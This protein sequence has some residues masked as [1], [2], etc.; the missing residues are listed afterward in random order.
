MNRK[1]MQKKTFLK[2]YRAVL[3]LSVLAIISA[4]Q[5]E[6]GF[7]LFHKLESYNI[8]DR[9]Q[10]TQIILYKSNP[11]SYILKINTKDEEKTIYLDYKSKEAYF[12]NRYAFSITNRF[13]IWHK[14]DLCQVL[15]DDGVKAEG[16][17]YYWNEKDLVLN[18]ES[19][20]ERGIRISNS[21]FE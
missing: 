10:K 6:Y 16:Y 11:I 2:L 8:V 4:F 18:F 7:V 21:V 13:L 1:R 14:H 12:P 5:L 9:G 17:N 15:V 19:Y 20:S 3:I